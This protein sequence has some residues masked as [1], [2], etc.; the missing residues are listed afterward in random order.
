M[1]KRFLII[2]GLLLSLCNLASQDALRVDTIFSAAAGIRLSAIVTSTVTAA[3][4]FIATP[5]PDTGQC[6]SA[7]K[8]KAIQ[9]SSSM[10]GPTR[11]P[12]A[13]P[14]PSRQSPTRSGRVHPSSSCH[15]HQS[16]QI[17]GIW[18]QL[19]R[20]PLLRKI[21]RSCV[22]RSSGLAKAEGRHTTGA[23]PV[24][25]CLMDHGSGTGNLQVP[26]RS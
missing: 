16:E 6:W 24:F 1:L 13:C 4:I 9:M 26:L 3:A 10:A 12:P 22:C 23:C 17:S 7:S 2:S 15:L 11:Q 8:S 5:S 14:P 25:R 20:H 18:R 19:R 21:Y